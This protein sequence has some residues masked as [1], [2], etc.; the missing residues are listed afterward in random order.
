MFLRDNSR[1]QLLFEG[2][3]VS[4]GIA[5]GTAFF[6]P[7][8]EEE[9]PEFPITVGEVDTEISRYRRALFSSKEDLRQLQKDLETD[10]SHEAVSLIDTHIQ[11]LDDPLITTHVE[12]KIR[13][14]LQNTESVFRSVIKDY[15]KQFF[16]RKSDSFFHERYVDVLDL[17]KRILGHLGNRPG[18]SFEIP[19]GSVIFAKELTPSH[20]AAATC[21]K[22]S[23]FVTQNGGGNSHSALI[24]RAKGLPFVSNIVI[25]NPFEIEGQFVI[26]NGF[27][28][29]VII[30][31]EEKTLKAHRELRKQHLSRN[32]KFK[33]EDKHPTETE[34]GFPIQL[35]SN[36]GNLD[37]LDDFPYKTA[38]IGLFRSEYLFLHNG[39]F[40]PSEEQQYL[41]Y[42]QLIDKAGG[43]PIIVRVF[44]IGGDKN[45]EFFVG[46]EKEP[47]PVLGC[48]GIRFLLKNREFFKTQLRALLRAALEGEIHLLLP[49]ISDLNEV[50]ESKWLI[51][52][53]KKEL[54]KDGVP[55]KAIVPL[56]CMIEVPSAVMICEEVAAHS[57]FLSMGTNDLVQYTLGMDR[58]NPST[59][60]LCYPAHPSI[61][62]LIKMIVLAA[63]RQKK[64]LTICGEMASNPLFIPLLLG[65]GLKEFSC[66]LRYIPIIKKAIRK[67]SIIGVYK[68]AERALKMHDPHEIAKLLKEY[69][70]C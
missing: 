40:F 13:L 24:A 28:G 5:I 66:S 35:F 53:V 14:M 29:E 19:A 34:D 46:Q 60:H 68:L 57:D 37:E 61:L 3:P 26:V 7:L 27:T 11:M 42:R 52:E 43:G 8:A 25:P 18:L 6:W 62:R 20:T 4:E 36:V 38:G 48:R 70:E 63:E 64:P 17:S 2:D 9:I 33:E 51:E 22:S 59:N 58:S 49:L 45:P 44:D 50:K 54:T 65:L 55:F 39:S 23:G 67:C 41:V 56:G 16:E 47:N 1:K 15:E 12:D 10:E 21:S 30:N 31:P 69:D 32:R